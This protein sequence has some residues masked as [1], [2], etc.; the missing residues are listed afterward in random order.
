MPIVCANSSRDGDAAV[1]AARALS[2]RH[3][4]ADL[5][6]VA[7]DTPSLEEVVRSSTTPVLVVRDPAPFVAWAAGEAPLRAV[8][9]WDDTMT[10]IAAVEHL[11]ALRRAGPVDVEIVRVYFPDE[12]A[13]RYG[14]HVE[15]LVEPVPALEALLRRDIGHQL[16]GLAGAGVVAITPLFGV[17]RVSDR[18]IEY[19]EATRTDLLVVGD[20]HRGGLRRLSSVAAH[21]VGEAR[22]SVLLAPLRTVPAYGAS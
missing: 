14:V 18:L 13:R 20:H 16:E 11:V 7:G 21:V 2:A 10:T 6:V 22:V 4:D 17:G 9:G 3:V 12:A 19:A 5:L 1:L 15:S 8:L